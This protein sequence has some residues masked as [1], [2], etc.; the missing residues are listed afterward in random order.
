V[1]PVVREM[2]AQEVDLVVDYFHGASAEHL[3][4]LGVDPTRLPAPER[5]RQRLCDELA[6]PVG[7][8]AAL[9]VLWELDGEPVGFSSAD[10]IDYGE[11]AFMHLHVLH[12]RHRQSGIGTACVRLS[13]D[14]YFQALALQRVLCEPNAFNVGPNRTLQRAGFQYVK[15][16]RTVPGPL[17]YHQAVTRWAL[18]RPR[19]EPAQP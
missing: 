18:E 2:R 16:H 7:Q 4:M 14:H 10:K 12:S 8:R 13:A 6:T 19:R 11:Q 15:T 1:L 3:E 5:W 9:L 17:N